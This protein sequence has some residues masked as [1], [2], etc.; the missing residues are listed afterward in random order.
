MRTH[1]RNTLL[2]GGALLLF[3]VFVMIFGVLGHAA[4][5]VPAPSRRGLMSLHFDDPAPVSELDITRTIRA[6]RLKEAP[7]VDGRLD[8]EAWERATTLGPLRCA[9]SGR[10]AP[11]DTRVRLGHYEGVLYVG[12]RC[13]EADERR[14][15]AA[16]ADARI[17]DRDMVEILL[18]SRLDRRNAWVIAVGPGGEVIE[19]A[20]GGSGRDTAWDSGSEVA[21]RSDGQ[22]WAVE[23][24]V[25]RSALESPR[26]DLIGFNFV[27]RRPGTEGAPFT[28]NPA[29][30]AFEEGRW[31]GTLSFETYPC[32]VHK[33]EV[34]WPHVGEN[35][36][37]VWV[38]NATDREQSLRAGIVTHEADKRVH[39]SKFR[40]AVPAN[41]TAQY[42]FSH[43]IRAAGP[44]ALAVR[45]ADEATEKTVAEF[46]RPNLDIRPSALS[47]D[48]PTE[49]EGGILRL[50]FRIL[51]PRRGLAEMKMAATV[52]GAEDLRT[53]TRVLRRGPPSRTGEILIR[54]DALKPGTYQVDSH[55]WH[56]KTTVARARKEF[57][58]PAKD[59]AARG[60]VPGSVPAHK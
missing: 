22:G 34:G 49:G 3:A 33:V 20:A 4:A 15:R 18:D 27:R 58:I 26:N 47:L 5:Q 40:F 41:A 57:T 10:A 44:C 32:S 43:R 56:R 35:R 30:R 45:L 28:W 6:P 14:R 11:V 50:K 23:M 21:V 25:A 17:E 48:P 54:A 52:R 53:V 2:S 16:A 24:A 38:H 9:G 39:Q 31:L 12:A 59:G 60:A 7:R 51:L 29:P 42:A 46:V 1:E 37:R 55:L 13:R 36:F 19:F 8:D